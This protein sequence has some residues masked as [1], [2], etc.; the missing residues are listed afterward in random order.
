MSLKLK[1]KN[2][3]SISLKT[4]KEKAK[5][6]CEEENKKDKYIAYFRDE[7]LTE[8]QKKAVIYVMKKSKIFSKNTKD[9]VKLKFIEKSWDHN[10]IPNIINHIAECDVVIHFRIQILHSFFKSDTKHRNLFEIMGKSG[11]STYIQGRTEW[12]DNLFSNIYHD[13]LDTEKVKYGCINLYGTNYGCSSANAYG[14]SHMI[15]KSNV[16]K[17]CS[18]ICGDSSGMQP[19]IAN[20]ENFYQ[21]L[22][23]LNDST[24]QNL[25]RIVKGE[26]IQEDNYLYVEVQIHGDVLWNRDIEKIVIDK[27]IY[28]GNNN[29]IQNNISKFQYDF[30]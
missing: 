29:E 7:P 27:R 14:E 10:L 13:A 26:K 3:N 30:F 2:N 19:H 24:I 17:R 23:Y 9:S 5:K 1:I 11:G 25:I 28:N 21:L 4:L 15:L 12:E 22:L 20:F 16:K 8:V 6:K 18:F